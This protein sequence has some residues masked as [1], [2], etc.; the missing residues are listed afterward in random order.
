MRSRR[1]RFHEPW[2]KIGMMDDGLLGGQGER[3]QA[4]VLKTEAHCSKQH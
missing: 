1:R 2:H 4:T 3:D